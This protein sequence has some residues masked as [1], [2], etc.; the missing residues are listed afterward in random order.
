MYIYIHIYI[1]IYIHIYIYII[2]IFI[3]LCL[4]FLL[5]T[6]TNHRTAGQGGEHFFD[7]YFYPFHRHRSRTI[8]AESSPLHIAS[9]RTRIGKLLFPSASR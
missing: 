6:F 7:Y 9:S 3:S 4:G 8:T 1:Y 5:R 2:Y